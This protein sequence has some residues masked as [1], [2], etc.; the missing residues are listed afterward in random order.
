MFI[1]FLKSVAVVG[2]RASL[3]FTDRHT[4]SLAALVL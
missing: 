1:F 2:G 4:G 3:I